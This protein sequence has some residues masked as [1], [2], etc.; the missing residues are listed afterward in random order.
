MVAADIVEYSLRSSLLEIMVVIR[1]TSSV[2]KEA[3]ML[4]YYKSVIFFH[5]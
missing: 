4:L 1:P 3:H 2:N 5:I